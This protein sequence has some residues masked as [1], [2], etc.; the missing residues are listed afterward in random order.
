[1][2]LTEPEDKS[3]LLQPKNIIK[4]QQIT[5]A[6]LYYAG[7]VDGTLMTNLNKLAYTQANGTQGTMRATKTIMDY[8]HTHSDAKIQYCASQMKLQ[9]HSGVLY[10]SA[11]KVRSRAGGQFF[12]S[13]HLDTSSPTKQNG[14]VLVV[15]SILKILMTTPRTTR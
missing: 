2:Q 8:C 5:R 6:I 1:M 13:D 11:S 15:A 14:A 9:I 7:A 3:T 4:L 10:L 12:L